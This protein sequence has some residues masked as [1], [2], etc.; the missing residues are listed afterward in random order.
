MKMQKVIISMMLFLSVL[1]LSSQVLTAEELVGIHNVTDAEM[2]AI[3]DPIEGTLAYNTT[4]KSMYFFDG[5]DWVPMEANTPNVYVGHLLIDSLGPHKIEDI[6]F[7]P[8]K[9]TFAAHA[10]IE[11]LTIDTDNGLEN[12][13]GGLANSINN[14]SR[15]ASPDR[16]IGIRY[17][18]QNG[19]KLG[20][21]SESPP[22]SAIFTK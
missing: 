9:I 3:V 8:T 15:Y 7:K 16:C 12:N 22:E 2:I 19:D 20:L 21:T 18:S 13:H 11:T 1:S 17:G 6:P 4:S 10:N 14:I 5:A